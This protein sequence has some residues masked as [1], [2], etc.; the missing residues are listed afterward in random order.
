MKQ[1]ENLAEARAWLETFR[2]LKTCTLWGT[3]VRGG[4][5]IDFQFGEAEAAK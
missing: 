2:P 4:T 5:R 1:R 3:P